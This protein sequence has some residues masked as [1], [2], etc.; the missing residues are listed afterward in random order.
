M[1]GEMETGLCLEAEVGLSGE[2]HL[3]LGKDAEV[4]GRD[5]ETGLG[6]DGGMGLEL[7]RDTGMDGE[8]RLTISETGMETGQG[9]C[10][11]T[12][13]EPGARA[14]WEIDGKGETLSGGANDVPTFLFTSAPSCQEEE[15]E[16]GVT[17]EERSGAEEGEEVGMDTSEVDSLQGEE[18]THRC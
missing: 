6:V 10:G 1:W 15:E 8:T 11:E 18:L 5:M 17:G 3:S 13:A 9:G 4:P 12:G 7:D 14:D 2:K 16:R